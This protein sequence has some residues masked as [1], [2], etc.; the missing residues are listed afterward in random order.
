MNS[1][2]ISRRYKII[3]FFE[4]SL[5]LLKILELKLTFRSSVLASPA[6]FTETETTGAVYLKCAKV[7]GDN[8][9]RSLEKQ[10]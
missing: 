1:D 6:E 7:T 5:H 4:M 9:E 3:T 2:C 10:D 8:K